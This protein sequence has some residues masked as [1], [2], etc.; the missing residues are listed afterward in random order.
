MMYIGL[1]S[2]AFKPQESIYIGP[3]LLQMGNNEV[4]SSFVN[5]FWEY[6]SQITFAPMGKPHNK[7]IKSAQVPFG[8]I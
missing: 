7:P 5:L 6:N 3:I 1:A 2:K 4:A 8:D